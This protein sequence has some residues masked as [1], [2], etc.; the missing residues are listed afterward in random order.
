MLFSDGS[1]CSGTWRRNTLGLRNKLFNSDDTC[2]AYEMGVCR[3]T[4]QM[5]PDD[6]ESLKA[7]NE[8]TPIIDANESWCPVFEG[9]SEDKL[10]FCLE[11]WRLYTGDKGDLLLAPNT[12]TVYDGCEG[13]FLADDKILSPV[14]ISSSPTMFGIRLFTH[15]DTVNLIQETRKICDEDDD[16]HCFMSGAP[17]QYW[18]QYINIDSLL[19]ESAWVSVSTGFGVSFVFLFFMFLFDKKHHFL[20]IVFGSLVGALIIGIT[21]VLSITTVV[22]LSALA[23]VSLTAFSVMSFILSIGFVVEYSVHITHRFMTAPLSYS[24]A[25]ERV[26]YAM[27]FLFLPTFMSFVSSTI[28]VICLAFTKFTFTQRFFFRPLV[29]VMFVTYFFGCYFLPVLL[30]LLEFDFLKL[31][32]QSQNG[33][34]SLERKESSGSDLPA[35]S[36]NQ[37]SDLKDV[38]V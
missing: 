30:S 2:Q 4:S 26:E 20:K 25:K 21:C 23:D 19:F 7:N 5:H 32:H 12:A 35:S 11:K 17:Y 9:W 14:K 8:Y 31:G 27:S 37:T 3:P 34:A 24:S 38:I 36:I 13:E 22:G 28:G 18:E 6:L 10:K 29:I 16:V 33:D 1:T 15:Q